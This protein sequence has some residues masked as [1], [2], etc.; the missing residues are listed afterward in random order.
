MLATKT[1]FVQD[2]R[3]SDR[4]EGVFLVKYKALQAG[5]T[6]KPYLNIV[7]IDKTG[8]IEARV[9]DDAEAVA[10][11]FEKDDFVDIK[12]RAQAYQGRVQLNVFEADRRDAASLN[13]ADFLP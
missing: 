9:W 12:G 1:R 10:G 2:I 5:K 4:V 8:E 11:R 3:E 13:L 7:L 6:G